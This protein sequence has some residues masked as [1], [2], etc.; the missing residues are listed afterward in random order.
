MSEVF[1][2]TVEFPSLGPVCRLGLASRGNTDLPAEAVHEAIDRGVNYLNWCG[3]EN[4]MRRAIAELG[5]QRDNV[6][7]AVQLE[8]RS[9]AVAQREFEQICTELNTDVI[10]V[11]TY[12]YVEDQHD[13]DRIHESDGAAGYL[14]MLKSEGR[15]KSIGLTSHQRPLATSFVETSEHLDMLM[16]RYN[17]AHRGA[18]DDIF[19]SVE[20]RLPIVSF[21][22]LRWG[23]LLRPTPTD[24]PDFV[25][26]PA[27]D[28]YRFAL[29]PSA[30]S[31]TLMAPNDL[32]ELRQNLSLLDEW[33]GLSEE[34]HAELAAHGNRV[35]EHAGRFP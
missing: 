12:Y 2:K 13:W 15:I 6:K 16:I 34:R 28:W 3:T 11:V 4:G 10:D 22:A 23:A 14:E 30:V 33:Q 26:P 32:E 7:I 27:I 20:G 29:A 5:S 31:V 18:E 8:S 9:A 35:R 21:T 17:A 24:P 19:P 25:I 1:P